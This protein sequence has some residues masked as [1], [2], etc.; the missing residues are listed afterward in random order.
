MPG[1]LVSPVLGRV[2]IYEPPAE[3]KLIC[4]L[5]L[6]DHEPDIWAIT[7]P[8]IAAYA[9][10]TQSDFHVITERRYPYSA[11]ANKFLIREIG[12]GY[13]WVLFIDSDTI[14]NPDAPDW[15]AFLDK[16]DV[17]F[18]ALDPSP[19]RF[20]PNQYNKRHRSYRG[21]CTWLVGCSNWTLDDLWTPYESD[22]AYREC[23]QH[24]FPCSHEINSGVCD[25]A[26]LCDDYQ[27]STNIAR[28][29]LHTQTVKDLY[30]KLGIAASP[31]Y[32]L[33]ATDAETKI[34]CLQGVL[35]FWRQQKFVVDDK[36][37]ISIP[38]L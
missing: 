31:W 35:D 22:A 6:D 29:G 15:T 21:A 14:V 25:A 34:R 11:T 10:K 33:Y 4:T 38:G 27:L 8:T 26:H 28:F 20:R 18:N 24:I 2:P 5:R 36:F 32:H 17:L 30:P 16:Q 3:R 23:Q 13:D 1:G 19:I 7:E 12:K 9:K 37:N